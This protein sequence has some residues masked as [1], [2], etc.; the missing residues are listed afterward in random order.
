MFLR[1]VAGAFGN[2]LSRNRENMENKQLISRAFLI[3]VSSFHNSTTSV[4]YCLNNEPFSVI[5]VKLS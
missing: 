1:N 3:I 5:L 4:T 2:F